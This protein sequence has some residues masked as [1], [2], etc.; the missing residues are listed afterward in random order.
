[1]KYLIIILFSVATSWAC[2]T[3][4]I[5][6]INSCEVKDL[7]VPLIKRTYPS[8]N[9]EF[10]IPEKNDLNNYTEWDLLK[11]KDQIDFSLLE[12][13]LS[14]WKT[15]QI[16]KINFAKKVDEVSELRMAAELCGFG[17]PNMAL[18]KK[19]IKKNM[20]QDKLDCLK[21]KK[22]KIDAV[23]NAEKTK[24]NKIKQAKQFIKNYNC[25]QI[26]DNYQKALCV[27]VKGKL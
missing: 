2:S 13:E 21:S 22:A 15:K 24:S 14:K 12:A 1:M 26:Q 7:L 9:I 20:D 17:Q 6:T 3:K 27:L 25:N 16:K 18:L 23:I 10:T 19:K 11:N 4:S 5:A 8:F